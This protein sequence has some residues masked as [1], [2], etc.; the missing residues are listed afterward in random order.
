MNQPL[1]SRF[2]I[3]LLSLGAFM[4]AVAADAEIHS[5]SGQLI[6]VEPRDL[7]MPARAP[8]EAI[9]LHSDGSGSTYLYLEQHNGARLTVL[10]VSDPAHITLSST[11]EMETLGAFDVE[12]T[13]GPNARLI[14]YRNGQGTTVLDLRKAN[15]PTV[16]AAP[17]LSRL[18]QEEPLGSTGLLATSTTTRALPPGDQ[19]VR[20]IDTSVATH[21][22]LLATVNHVVQ[23]VTFEETGTTFLLGSAG[24]TV[25]RRT[26]IEREHQIHEMQMHGN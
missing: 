8:A 13:L 16:H 15:H 9:F 2:A 17:A 7:P 23:R 26:D 6:V 3:I 5:R 18:Q 14:R 20:I 10:D 25:I 22:V 12:R 24:L 21:P 11:I 4:P 19:E 1:T